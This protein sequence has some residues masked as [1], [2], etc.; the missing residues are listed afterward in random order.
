VYIYM[1]D[2]PEIEDSGNSQRAFILNLGSFFDTPAN[3]ESEDNEGIIE[4]TNSTWTKTRPPLI[5]P[6]ISEYGD[7]DLRMT[8][9]YLLRA[10]EYKDSEI[11]TYAEQEVIIV[12]GRVD[13]SKLQ[14]SYLM[15]FIVYCFRDRYQCFVF[16]EM[17]S[18]I[19]YLCILLYHDNTSI[20]TN[21][22]CVYNAYRSFYML[23]LTGLT[24]SLIPQQKHGI[25]A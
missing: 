25:G 22:N 5:L 24:V 4:E 16:D 21:Y 2:T 15:I 18:E 6:T 17:N 7:N 8:V 23:P 10:N 19:Y 20:R 12:N 1:Y 9:K 14:V 11:N 13:Y 3:A